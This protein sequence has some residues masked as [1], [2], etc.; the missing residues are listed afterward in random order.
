MLGEQYAFIGIVV[1]TAL[2]PSCLLVLQ[3]DDHGTANPHT[4]ELC[5]AGF[6][7]RGEVCEA[8]LWAEVAPLPAHALRMSDVADVDGREAWIVG[9]GGLVLHSDDGGGRFE[10]VDLGTHDDL[11]FVWADE[12][13][14]VATSARRAWV[15]RDAGATFEASPEAPADLTRCL[16]FFGRVV[17]GSTLGGLY[18]FKIGE[19]S[20]THVPLD[21]G[22]TIVQ[23][24]PGYLVV[25]TET[26]S[27][28]RIR[29]TQEANLGAFYGDTMLP[30]GYPGYVDSLWVSRKGLVA[31]VMAD[32]ME[33]SGLTLH[34]STTRGKAFEPRGTIAPECA[35][36][37]QIEGGAG[38]IHVM[39][40][41]NTVDMP[42]T[43][44]VWTSRDSGETFTRGTWGAEFESSWRGANR[45]SFGT[46]NHGLLLTHRLRQSTDGARSSTPIEVNTL[47]ADWPGGLNENKA[48]LFP[49]ATRGYVVAMQNTTAV[50]RF[51]LYRTDDGGHFDEGRDL[52]AF[53]D[54]GTPT[55]V[56]AA[57]ED[58]LWLG[59][60]SDFAKQTFLRSEDG[61][62]TF[63][64][65]GLPAQGQAIAAVAL[66]PGGLGF[67]ATARGAV[68]ARPLYRSTDGGVTFGEVKLPD[69]T[70][71][72]AL[73]VLDAAHVVAVGDNG[74]ILTSEDGGL[75]FTTRRGGMPDEE[76]LLTVDFAPG[77]GVGWA[78][79]VTSAGE[80]ILLRTENGGA[81][82]SAQSLKGA[83][84]G[85]IVEVAAATP[86]R[87]SAVLEAH[88]ET[89]SLRM[90]QDGGQS[91][92]LRET[93]GGDTLRSITRLPDGETTFALGVYG[94][95]RS[96]TP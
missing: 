81:T 74:V 14:I 75:S 65:D 77:S 50:F 34:C 31:C 43:F 78:G 80:P 93:P 37:A 64:P 30:G 73:R 91:W 55:P 57:H 52:E 19:A 40:H 25:A 32:A 21:V 39:T 26:G 4:R 87:A 92:S 69:G 51:R 23:A 95:Y 88:D 27:T 44:E 94:L 90:T 60:G 68:N 46:P 76:Q 62:R 7:R 22:R 48:M 29:A 84:S 20:F 16:V 28:T 67:V 86:S 41:C 58:R 35:R 9:K 2:L 13:T 6:V 47:S 66:G 89:R 53:T 54:D 42:T 8:P 59:L 3:E 36:S 17:C 83:P 1:S 24:G 56:L 61:G 79:G 71:I 38:S 85:A 70:H 96:Q 5:S 12:E 49:T 18:H 11:D 82:W 45:M 15:S 33:T 72:R 63:L 10:R